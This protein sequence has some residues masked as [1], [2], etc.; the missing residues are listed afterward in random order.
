MAI[1]KYDF[2]FVFVRIS[3]IT[4]YVK[5]RYIFHCI[6]LFDWSTINIQAWLSFANIISRLKR[7]WGKRTGRMTSFGCHIAFMFPWMRTNCFVCKWKCLCA[8]YYA[9]FCHIKSIS[10]KTIHEE[11][12]PTKKRQ[13]PCRARESQAHS[14]FRTYHWARMI[15]YIK[16]CIISVNW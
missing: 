6:C 5:T 4:K 15:L 8:F 2:H 13:L 1:Y 14:Y 12:F 9:H 7:I 10:Y 3:G 11:Y 16:T